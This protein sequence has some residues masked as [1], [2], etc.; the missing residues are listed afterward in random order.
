MSAIEKLPLHLGRDLHG[1]DVTLP[2]GA[3]RRHFIALGGTGSGKTVLCKAL[4]EEC[5]RYNLP[6]VAVDLQG[7]ILSLAMQSNECPAGAVPVSDV[8]RSKY[9]ERLDVKVWTPGSDIGIPLSMAPSL[10]VPDVGAV[11]RGDRVSII[12]AAARG[13]GSILGNDK[14]ATIAGLYTILD[15]ASQRD[16][17]LADFDDLHAFLRDPPA[18]LEVEIDEAFGCS[19][20]RKKLSSSLRVAMIGKSGESYNLGRAID[21]DQ[22]FGLRC[23]GPA[24][25]GKARLS[26]IYLAH[27]TQDEQQDFLAVLFAY[28]KNWMLKQGDHL[29]G[30]LYIDEIA[31]FCPPVRKP[32]AKQGLI[33]LLK[34][35]RKYGL[36]LA[37]A[38]QSPG[39]LDYKALGNIGTVALGR[40]TQRQDIEKVS[41]LLRSMPGVDSDAIVAALPGHKRGDFVLINA[42]HLSTP[43]RMRGRWLATQHRLVTEAELRDRVRLGGA[44]ALA[45]IGAA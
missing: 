40:V 44:Q 6:V 10:Y 28:I 5:I 3:L 21:V 39:D 31:P 38:T 16:Y 45:R 29:S 8:T 20:V 15:L 11:V 42:D 37:L 12:D 17:R 25:Q 26:I 14:P 43:T 33:D 36:C 22:L 2:I 27:L 41:G 7:D 30:M 4:V 1:H 24:E 23:P 13:I 35:A 32:P 19:R 9:A 34:Q 18:E